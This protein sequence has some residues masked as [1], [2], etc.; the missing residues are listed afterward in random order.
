MQIIAQE[1]LTEDQKK[2]AIKDFGLLEMLSFCFTYTGGLTGPQMSFTWFRAFCEGRMKFETDE[3][4][5]PSRLV[6]YFGD[7]LVDGGAVFSDQ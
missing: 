3:N 7:Y 5:R 4:G 2:H 1:E 6:S